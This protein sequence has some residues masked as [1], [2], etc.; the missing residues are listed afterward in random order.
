MKPLSAHFFLISTDPRTHKSGGSQGGSG[1]QKAVATIQQ[2]VKK[3][4]S[5]GCLSKPV[6]PVGDPAGGLTTY[7]PPGSSGKLGSLEICGGSGVYSKMMVEFGFFT[8]VHDILIH[9]D[10]DITKPK[11]LRF[12]LKG[13]AMRV[14]DV[15]HIS[16]E[17]TK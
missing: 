4:E 12:V 5:T 14:W 7:Y 17:C 2:I 11:Y 16:T 8:E 1:S 3:K 13:I 15:V 6:A 10:H 9:P